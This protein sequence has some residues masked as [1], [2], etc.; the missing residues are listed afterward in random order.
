LENEELQ[1]ISV[2]AT[3]DSVGLP[4]ELRKGLWEECAKTATMMENMIIT[5]NKPVSISQFFEKEP[6]YARSLKTFGDIG[7]MANHADKRSE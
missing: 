3:M 1:D 7:V 2:A 4:D 6:P 5:T